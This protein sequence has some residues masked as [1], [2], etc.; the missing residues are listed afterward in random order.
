M[1]D[2]KSIFSMIRNASSLEIY[3]RMKDKT[4]VS[5]KIFD[6]RTKNYGDESSFISRSYSWGKVSYQKL[7]IL[8]ASIKNR[9][10][11]FRG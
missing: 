7:K 5:G 1:K 10:R 8:S 3:D 4:W 6:S 2:K 9:L 11:L